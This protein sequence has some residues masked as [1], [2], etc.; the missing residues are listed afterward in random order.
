MLRT[1]GF[2]LATG[3][4]ATVNPCGFAL[5]PAYLAAFVGSQGDDPADRPVRRAIGVSTVLTLGFITVFGLVGLVI[6]SLFE[7]LR[8]VLPWATVVIGIVL[9]LLGIWLLLGHQLQVMLPKVNQ[10]GADGTLM[11]M[12]LFGVSYAVA[13]LSCTIGP[14]LT[15]TSATL[16]SGSFVMRVVS[17]VLYGV[18]MGLVVM[19]L[20]IAVALARDGI[21][22]R[23]RQLVPVIGRIS[24]ALMVIAGMYVA[25]YGWYEVRLLVLGHDV[26]D[27]PIVGAALSIQSWLVGFAPNRDTVWG[28]VIA[29]IAI[30]ALAVGGNRLL[31]TRRNGST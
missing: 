26:G 24:G 16:A 3:M 1:F 19:V 2:A 29:I 4:I 9:M 12:Y 5:L 13:S 18:G 14:F 30:I 7:G 20:T 27:D 23:F 28:W 31:H 10:G 25:Y 6:S 8:D 22:N 21:V 15:A 17:F 11:S